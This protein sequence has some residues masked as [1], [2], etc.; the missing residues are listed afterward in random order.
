MGQEQMSD[1]RNHTSKTIVARDSTSGIRASQNLILHSHSDQKKQHKIRENISKWKSR[2]DTRLPVDLPNIFL[3]DE[4]NY[5]F[6]VPRYI[7]E[8]LPEILFKNTYV[9][10]NRV[11][12]GKV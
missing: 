8:K 10:Q 4:V 3:R 9:L 6:T 11:G 5:D 12:E 2:I 1:V 7:L